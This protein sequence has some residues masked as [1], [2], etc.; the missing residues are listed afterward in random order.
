L[1]D[2]D[3]IVGVIFAT[4]GLEDLFQIA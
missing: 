3:I 2:H 1:R 4:P